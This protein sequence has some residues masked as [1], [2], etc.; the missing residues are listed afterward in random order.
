MK[1]KKKKRTENAKIEIEFG[2][3]QCTIMA[4]LIAVAAHEAT[5]QQIECVCVCEC[6][7]SS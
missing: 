1:Q 4:R 7:A 2:R 5:V 3:N 6:V